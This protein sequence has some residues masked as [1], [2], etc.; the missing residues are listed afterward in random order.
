MDIAKIRKKAKEQ[1]AEK[2]QE[3]PAE[4]AAPEISASSVSSAGEHA[5]APAFP[6]EFQEEAAPSRQEELPSQPE[7][8]A[9][10]ES[11]TGEDELVELLTFSLGAEEFAFKVSEVEEILRLQRITLVPTMPGYIVGITSLRG[12]IIPVLDLK[13]RL[14]LEEAGKMPVFDAEAHHGKLESK[15]LIVAGPKGFIGAVIDKVNGVVSLA[16]DNVIEPPA[17]L[18]EAEMKYIEGI[19]I[20]DKRFISVLRSD[21]TMNIEI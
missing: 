9:D 20:L 7:K 10:A 5:A 14:N 16:K 17:H 15:I 6:E 11:A 18:S 2:M 21:D 13:A 3:R 8:Y 1:G 4:T 12:K 19:V